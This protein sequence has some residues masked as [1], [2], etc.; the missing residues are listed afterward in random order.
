[1]LRPV[2]LT[3]ASQASITNVL[4]SHRRT[5]AS[6]SVSLSSLL[7]LVGGDGLQRIH[8]SPDRRR[9]VVISDYP[10]CAIV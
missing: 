1:V 4:R 3:T 6:M 2:A 8:L 5:S 9:L 10:S 7:D